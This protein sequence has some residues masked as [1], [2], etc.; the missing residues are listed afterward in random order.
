LKHF[1]AINCKVVFWSA[2]F[3][4]EANAAEAKLAGEENKPTKLK[5][6][7]HKDHDNDVIEEEEEE[8]EDE[9][10]NKEVNKSMPEDEEENEEEEE[11]DDDY[12]EEDEDENTEE[13][14]VKGMD[15]L[16]NDEKVAV[17]NSKQE[18]SE[19]DIEKCKVLTRE[20]LIHLFKTIHKGLE[21]IKPGSTTIGMVG[22]VEFRYFFI[23]TI[24]STKNFLLFLVIQTLVKVQQLMHCYKLRG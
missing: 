20:E 16:K 7:L 23:H 4:A 12:E 15:N 21:K 2:F 9:E 5:S 3:A 19:S 17:E 22:Y 18:H 6:E 13:E 8:D 24:K 10:E 1:E 11:D 14:L